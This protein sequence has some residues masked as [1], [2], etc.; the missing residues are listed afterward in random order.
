LL[1]IIFWQEGLESAQVDTSSLRNEFSKIV[2]P[3]YF[4]K[5]SEALGAEKETLIFEAENYYST[6][7]K[8]TEDIS[9]LL[10]NLQ[11]DVLREHLSKLLAELAHAETVKDAEK[12]TLISQEISR[13]HRDMTSLETKR[14]KV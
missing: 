7:E 2:G 8:L 3:E 10:D 11:D 4:E 5:L 1:G 6:P 12:V 14:E 9:E 13:V